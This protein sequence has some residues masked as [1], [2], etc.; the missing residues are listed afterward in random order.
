[1]QELSSRLG[2]GERITVRYRGE[3]SKD[4]LK[5]IYADYRVQAAGANTITVSGDGIDSGKLVRTL[6]EH[7]I[8]VENVEEQKQSLEDIY[9]SIVQKDEGKWN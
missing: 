8:D 3:I 4:L 9:L 2:V 1:M 5:K 6:V 7:G